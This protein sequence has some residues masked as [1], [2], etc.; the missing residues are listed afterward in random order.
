MPKRQEQ[1]LPELEEPAS[2]VPADP[3]PAGAG[4][5]G[6]NAEHELARLAA[7]PL[8]EH[9]DLYQGIHAELHAALAAI[10]DA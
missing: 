2:P 8:A 6:H 4:A 1:T 5:L 9:P 7:L 3:G 10:D